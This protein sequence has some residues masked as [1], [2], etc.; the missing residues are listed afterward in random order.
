VTVVELLE[1]LRVFRRRYNE[2]WLIERHSYRTPA[3][4]RLDLAAPIPA[5]A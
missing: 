3:Q 2:Q 5:V 1:A 4:V